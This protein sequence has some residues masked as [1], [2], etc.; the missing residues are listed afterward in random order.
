MILGAY[1]LIVASFIL[2]FARDTEASLMVAISGVHFTV[3]FGVPAVIF[4]T[5]ARGSYIDLPHFL[6]HGWN[7][8]TDHV[9]RYEAIV[10]ILL[11]PVV[12]YHRDGGHFSYCS[13]NS[14]DRYGSRSNFK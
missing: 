4:R 3:Y 12:R 9:D 11:F 5:E 14:F 13:L 8:W 2:L 1:A 7:T 10:Q 6:K